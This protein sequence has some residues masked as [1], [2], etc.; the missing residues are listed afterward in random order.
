V[1]KHRVFAH[2][3]LGAVDGVHQ[4]EILGLL[5]ARSRFFPRRRTHRDGNRALENLANRDFRR[6]TSASVT[7]D[8]IGL[9]AYFEVVLEQ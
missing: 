2:E 5:V 3:S 7:G 4:P 9:D 8:F 6:R 1:E